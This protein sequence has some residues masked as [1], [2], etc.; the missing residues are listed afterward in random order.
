M[1]KAADPLTSK[2]GRLERKAVVARLR[3]RIRSVGADSV[4]GIALGVELNFMLSRQKRYD[5]K[6]GGL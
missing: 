1:K 6:T 5:K 3:R 2:G 4:V